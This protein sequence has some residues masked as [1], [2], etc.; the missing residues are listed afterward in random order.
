MF[1]LFFRFG[2][3]GI[4][5]VTLPRTNRMKTYVGYTHGPRSDGYVANDFINP[6]MYF[7]GFPKDHRVIINLTKNQSKIKIIQNKKIT[8][9]FFISASKS[10][11]K[12]RFLRPHRFSNP[13]QPE[14]RF[15]VLQTT[16]GSSQPGRIRLHRTIFHKNLRQQ[17]LLL[18]WPRILLP[19]SIQL[20]PN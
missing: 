19:N 13:Q 5:N 3:Y 8:S 2:N 18:R 10:N 9:F 11:R 1:L 7:G 6:V 17:M 15:M 20:L 16:K 12:L 14:H 4:L